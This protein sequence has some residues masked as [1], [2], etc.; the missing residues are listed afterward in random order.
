MKL[1]KKFFCWLSFA[2][3]YQIQMLNNEINER[4][5]QWDFGKNLLYLVL[6]PKTL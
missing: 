1:K 4:N 3:L 5:F 2:Y 6:I